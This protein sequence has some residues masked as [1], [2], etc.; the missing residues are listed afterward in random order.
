[1]PISNLTS[2]S[3]QSLSH[4][5]LRMW[6]SLKSCLRKF[7]TLYRRHHIGMNFSPRWSRGQDSWLSPRRPGF[8]SR[9]GR[10]FRSFKFRLTY[11]AYF[12]LHIYEVYVMS[13]IYTKSCGKL[14]LHVDDPT[15]I[16]LVHRSRPQIPESFPE[17][18]FYKRVYPV[19]TRISSE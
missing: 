13:E 19:I 7:R 9:S 14:N 18:L 5:L 16:L 11:D 8:D 17:L 10:I 6:S 4:R 15:I 3:C 2:T 1:M 12:M